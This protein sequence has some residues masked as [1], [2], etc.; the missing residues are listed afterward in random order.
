MFSFVFKLTSVCF[1]VHCVFLCFIIAAAFCEINELNGALAPRTLKH[2]IQHCKLCV[3]NALGCLLQYLR[4]VRGYREQFRPSI[5]CGCK[6]S[7]FPLSICPSM[8]LRD[9]HWLDALGAS[10]R[11]IQKS[12]RGDLNTQASHP[13]DPNHC[14]G[15]R[16]KYCVGTV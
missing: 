15:L 10:G 2:L 4:W 5:S 7:K 6:I 12:A 16:N 11:W 8:E 13:R 9:V 1:C 14:V 3:R